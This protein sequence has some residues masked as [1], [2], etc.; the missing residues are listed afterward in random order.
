MEKRNVL[1]VST[2]KL[3]GES[4]ESLLKQADDV[5]LLGPW[6]P[7]EEIL[8]KLAENLP[9]V[10]VMV[11]DQ[12]NND[13]IHDLTTRIMHKFPQL[14]LILAGIDMAVFYVIN[15]KTHPARGEDLLKIIRAMQV[16]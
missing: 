15:T 5:N 3:F 11:E 8:D 9:D 13:K 16:T 12:E 2:Q 6:E 14:P 7:N 4:M 10:I 1:L